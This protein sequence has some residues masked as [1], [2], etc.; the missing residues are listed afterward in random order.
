MDCG[1]ESFRAGA[2][3]GDEESRFPAAIRLLF[4]DD[5]IL[6]VDGWNWIFGGRALGFIGAPGVPQI[7]VGVDF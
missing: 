6:A 1:E 5:G 3:A 7:R 4:P 2:G